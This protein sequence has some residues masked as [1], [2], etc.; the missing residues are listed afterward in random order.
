MQFPVEKELS[1]LPTRWELSVMVLSGGNG[2]SKDNGYAG[3][4]ASEHRFGPELIDTFYHP[5]LGR[6]NQQKRLF[7]RC[8]V[9]INTHVATI[10]QWNLGLWPKSRMWRIPTLPSKSGS[11][12]QSKKEIPL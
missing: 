2:C 12:S 5:G 11:Q 10:P 8:L 6:H 4:L 7:T 9:G 1:P 3:R